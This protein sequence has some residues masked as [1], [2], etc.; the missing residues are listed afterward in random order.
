M[1]KKMIIGIISG[2]VVLVA[3]IIVALLATKKIN[4]K[5]NAPKNTSSVA[6]SSNTVS[7]ETASN[8]NSESTDTFK[9]EKKGTDGKVDV[10]DIAVAKKDELITVPVYITKNPG[11]TASKVVLSFDTNVFEYSSC[12]GGEIFDDCSGNFTNGQIILI[13]SDSGLNDIVGNGI[14]AN[15][16]LKK[17]D[18]AKAGT[19]SVTVNNAECEFANT[20]EELVSA[21]LEVGKITIK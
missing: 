12:S 2:V 21:T 5:I 1:N 10:K 18:T 17:K 9:T 13:A 6:D 14:L 7:N 4:F 8:E 15:V 16:V 3:A 19:Y 11:I 20:S